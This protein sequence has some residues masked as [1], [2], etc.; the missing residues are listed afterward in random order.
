MYYNGNI[1]TLDP[2]FT[3]NTEAFLVEDERFI[4]VGKNNDFN[5][6][7]IQKVNLFGKTVIPGF[8]DAHIHLWKVGQL[9][10]YI[11]DLRDASSI[12]EIGRAISKAA[13]NKKPGEWIIGRGFNESKLKE[14]IIPE[15][16]HLDSYAPENPVYLLRTCAHI[17]VLNTLGL[18]VCQIDG[19]T[20]A[21]EGGSVGKSGDIV[22]GRLYETALG[23]A[24]KHLP[25]TSTSDYAEMIS[26]GVKK[27]LPFG[28]T[29]ITDP[30]VHPPLLDAYHQ[31]SPLPIRLNLIPIL[32]EDGE[33]KPHELP[34]CVEGDYLQIRWAKLFADGGLSGQTAALD[35]PYKNSSE[36]GILRIKPEQFLELASTA[37]QRGY[38]L[39]THA[40]GDKA[41]SMVLN[42]YSKLNERYGPSRN[43]IEHFGLPTDES[44]DL[45]LKTGTAV[46][47]Q[48]IFL[49][50]LGDNFISSLDQQ[51]LNRCYPIQTLLNKN[52]PF[53][54]STDAPVVKNINPWR[55]IQTAIERKT[56]SEKVI[57]PD[58]KISLSNALYASTIGGAFAEGKENS[59]GSISA[60]KL[61][62]F[63]V[64]D[65]DPYGVE[66]DELTSIQAIS[67]FNGG[68]KVFEL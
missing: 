67:V 47:P 61:A 4:G 46:V 64:L 56:Q 29:S 60:G 53:A 40:I 8:N 12:E 16:Q 13:T 37:K 7:G 2:R 36:K 5:I 11:L 55:N 14:G 3:E 31:L 41:I 43:R 25:K 1:L 48:T 10:E 35:R 15:A 49:Y 50:E 24:T 23:L 51:Y 21:P 44:L 30:A 52:I 27:L 66:V 18:K 39:A 65:R 17:A 22:N 45:A 68:N 6:P 33:S 34:P 54:L 19:S 59:K 9:E 63:V 38:N 32:L 42:A 57:S 28:I 58:E 62:D 26:S 20:P